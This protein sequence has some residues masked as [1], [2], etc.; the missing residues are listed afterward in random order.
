M[1][2]SVIVSIAALFIAAVVG[3]ATYLGT[4][5]VA[6][7]RI[8][9]SNA[10][11]LWK[12]SQAMYDAVVRERDDARAQRDKLMS[13]QADQVIPILSAVLQAVQQL[14]TM[15]R[16]MDTRDSKCYS[17]VKQVS[18]IIWRLYR[19]WGDNSAR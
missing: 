10:E 5:R 2:T 12:Q 16:E 18:D 1:T 17:E 8:S 6:S 14:T 11:V 4:R 15:I 7:G 9:T 19:K 3:V 13:A